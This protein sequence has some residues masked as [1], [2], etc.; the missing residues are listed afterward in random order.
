M[1]EKKIFY[2][3]PT[4]VS[5]RS[6]V[7]IACLSYYNALKELYPG[8][9]VL[10]MPEEYCVGQYA[11]AVKIPRRKKIDALLSGCIHRYKSF[12]KAFLLKHHDEFAAVVINGSVHAGDMMGMMKRYGMKIIVIHH[13]YEREYYMQNKSFGTFGGRFPYIITHNER[14]AYKKAD[15]NLYLT[16]QDLE[17]ISTAYGKTKAENAIISVFDPELEEYKAAK[18][19]NTPIVAI[20][21]GMRAFQ[22][23]KSIEYF[24]QD[25]Y[26]ILSK[27]YPELQ[28]VLAGRSP[29]PAVYAFQEHNS[30]KVTLI[31]S[32][33]DMDEIIEKALIFLCPTC[34]GGGLKLHVMDG[35]RKGLPVFT[36]KV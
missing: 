28:L 11:D 12:M 16:K 1:I 29:N 17:L 13:N 10:G 21:G 35:L 25:Y 36:H 15:L 27:N 20:T 4:D 5:E 34:L 8:R 24:E 6:G 2:L 14:N 23:Y 19:D 3:A 9:V 31:P 33:P 26:P 32:P 22:A 7:A 18:G 30:D